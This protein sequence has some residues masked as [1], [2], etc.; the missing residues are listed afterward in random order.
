MCR[1]ALFLA[2]MKSFSEFIR[3]MNSEQK[4]VDFLIEKKIFKDSIQCSRCERQLTLNRETLFFRCH[5]TSYVVRNKKKKI[6]V[7]CGYSRAIK[8]GTW[9]QDIRLP[10]QV[11]ITFIA[12]WLW[13]PPPRFGFITDDLSVATHTFVNWSSF[14]REVSFNPFL[15]IPRAGKC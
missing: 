1:V 2:K 13:L 9:F 4:C 8:T 3:E 7:Q 15:N 12:E 11:A 14:C 5:S 6:K 10:L